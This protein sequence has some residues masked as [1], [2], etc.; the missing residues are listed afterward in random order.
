MHQHKAQQGFLTIAQNTAQ[1]DYLELAYLQAQNIKLTQKI[2]DTAIIVDEKTYQYFT[3]S[4]YDLFDHIIVLDQDLNHA[5]SEWKLANETQVFALTPFKE[6]LKVESDLIFASSIDH[7]W[8]AFRLKDICFS[9]GAKNYLQQP[10]TSRQ[11]REVFD[12]NHLPDIYTGLY[13]FR[14]SQTAADFFSLAQR[15]QQNWI[16]VRDQCLAMVTESVP[17]TDLLYALTA[18]I[19][20]PELCMI[21]S[22]DFIN[23]VHM[24]PAI[25]GYDGHCSFR[26]VFHCEF[27]QYQLRINNINQYHPVHYY[28]KDFAVEIRNHYNG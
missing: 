21:P 4:T 13:Y 17:S 28:E 8:P 18:Q 22:M 25:N 15:L 24:K 2:N 23:F 20:G 26:E 9:Y 6:T 27:D 10:S 1:V 16:S 19:L 7:W 14:Y 12:A 3:Q 11:Y 5:D